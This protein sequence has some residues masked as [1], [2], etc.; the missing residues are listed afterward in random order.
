MKKPKKMK[1]QSC[2]L[3]AAHMQAAT[4]LLLYCLWNVFYTVAN[5]DNIKNYTFQFKL[6]QSWVTQ[7]P[8]NELQLRFPYCTAVNHIR[9]FGEGHV[10]RGRMCL[11]C[12]KTPSLDLSL[13]SGVA[14]S[15]SEDSNTALITRQQIFL[16]EMVFYWD[17]IYTSD[18]GRLAAQRA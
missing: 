2:S 3:E 13:T 1:Q 11:Y 7:G 14:N 9:K 18:R 12:A 4:E 10:W 8:L 15:A 16:A 6:K 5:A 17:I